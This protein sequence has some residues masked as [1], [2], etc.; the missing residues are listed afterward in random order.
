GGVRSA[1]RAR[2]AVHGRRRRRRTRAATS[3]DRPL[4]RGTDRGARGG[5]PGRVPRPS[6]VAVPA[7]GA[8]VRRASRGGGRRV[9]AV[10]ELGEL[11][12]AH[13]GGAGGSVGGGMR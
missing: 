3:R 8:A 7:D 9:G 2:V 1:G 11:P 4:L 13:R 12:A 10:S 5:T 6:P